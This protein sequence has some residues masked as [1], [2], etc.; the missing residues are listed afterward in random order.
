MLWGLF[1]IAVI[2]TLN[3]KGVQTERQWQRQG[4]H[5]ILI[6]FYVNMLQGGG[7]GGVGFV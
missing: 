1:E 7:G 5:Q 4:E 3:S 6:K 2:L